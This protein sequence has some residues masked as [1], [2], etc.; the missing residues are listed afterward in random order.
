MRALAAS[1][2]FRCAVLHRPSPPNR[3]DHG[4]P[5]QENGR[6]RVHPPARVRR[7]HGRGDTGHYHV[8][9]DGKPLRK[10]NGM[11]SR[12]PS[13]P[14]RS[15]GAERRSSNYANS[16]SSCSE[17]S[18]STVRRPR[19]QAITRSP[20]RLVPSGSAAALGILL[21]NEQ[22]DAGARSDGMKPAFGALLDA[23]PAAWCD[24]VDEQRRDELQSAS[25]LAGLPTGAAGF[26]AGAAQGG[27]GSRARSMRTGRARRGQRQGNKGQPACTSVPVP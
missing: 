9:R 23:A 24:R 21:L 13:P 15:A 20:G 18:P 22:G 1:G 6:P 5:Q 3:F 19:P 14:T 25:R 2:L 7:A 11:P 12:S 17:T 4:P 27:L 10:H 26:R 16:A 8:L